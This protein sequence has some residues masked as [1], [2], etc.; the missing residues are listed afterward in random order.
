M[1]IADQRN[2]EG[3]LGPVQNARAVDIDSAGFFDERG[4]VFQSS[5]DGMYSYLPAGA[6]VD[7]RQ[8]L[9]AGEWPTV[10][11]VAILCTAVRAGLGLSIVVANL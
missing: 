5:V 11:G 6:S 4:F 7:L 9:N 3:A 2:F 8:Q 10:A 1:A